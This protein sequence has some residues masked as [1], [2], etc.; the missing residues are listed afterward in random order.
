[1]KKNRGIS[2]PTG[3]RKTTNLTLSMVDNYDVYLPLFQYWYAGETTLVNKGTDFL[4]LRGAHGYRQA[5][6]RLVD[7]L[8]T[9]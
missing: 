2:L 7:Q 4:Q 5:Y 6:L 9:C 1:M 8:C 3:V